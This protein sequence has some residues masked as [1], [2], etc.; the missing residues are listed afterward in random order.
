MI[1]DDNHSEQ[2]IDQEGFVIDYFERVEA[3]IVL[4]KEPN[5]QK[6]VVGF[7]PSLSKTRIQDICGNLSTRN[8]D[9]VIFLIDCYFISQKTTRAMPTSVERKQ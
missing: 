2:K 3:D 8:L 6:L 9:S 5:V 7:R 1:I 4:E